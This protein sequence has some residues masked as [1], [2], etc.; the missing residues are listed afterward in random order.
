MKPEIA[1]KRVLLLATE[2]VFESEVREALKRQL[3]SERSATC[4]DL[5]YFDPTSLTDFLTVLDLLAY[6]RQGVFDSIHI[7]PPA[8]TWARFRQSGIPGQPPLR[9]RSA[10][11]GLSS[12]SPTQDEKVRSANLIQEILSWC[13]EQALQ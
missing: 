11:L 8:A 7:L 3:Q 13:S 2:A 5:V 4:I 12:L 1:P 10:P 9:S 6:I